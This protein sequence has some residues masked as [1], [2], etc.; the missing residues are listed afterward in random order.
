MAKN[1]IQMN[2]DE[3]KSLIIAD[4]V[5]WEKGKSGNLPILKT[6]CRKGSM[7]PVA[8]VTQASR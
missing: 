7:L 1:Q 4:G 2:V 5:R 3:V 8:A 6:N